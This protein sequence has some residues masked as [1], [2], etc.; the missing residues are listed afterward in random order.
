MSVVRDDLRL[1]RQ[2]A[3]SGEEAEWGA[4]Y[5]PGVRLCDK[6][7]HGAA[8]T[9]EGFLGPGINSDLED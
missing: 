3:N 8:M 2:P 9:G 7:F 5:P 4:N 1:N 6:R